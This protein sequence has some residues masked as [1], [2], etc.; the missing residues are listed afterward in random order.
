MYA[1]VIRVA[2]HTGLRM[3]ELRALRWRD[4]D[5][6]NGVIHVRR[7]APVS[8]PPSAAE[9][10]AKSDVRSVPLT[11]VVCRELAPV[12]PPTALRRP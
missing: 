11:D 6:G 2:A 4:V 7:N 12:K 8:A 9:K 10:T 5:W 1:A 3:G